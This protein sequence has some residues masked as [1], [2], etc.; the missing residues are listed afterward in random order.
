MELIHRANWIGGG[1][2]QLQQVPK[3]AVEED[4]EIPEDGEIENEQNPVDTE[5]RSVIMR[6]DNLLIVDLSKYNTE[7][8]EA[9]YIQINHIGNQL[10][11]NEKITE[12]GRL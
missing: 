4:S 12:E 8:K 3:E 1:Y 7:R 2:Q 6:G 10:T 11:T 9:H 5:E